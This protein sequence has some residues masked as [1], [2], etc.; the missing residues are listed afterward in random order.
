MLASDARLPVIHVRNGI[1]Y[2]SSAHAKFS[3]VYQKNSQETVIWRTAVLSSLNAVH[4]GDACPVLEAL[5]EHP[6]KR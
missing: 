5:S 4:D 6:C 2:Y 3:F 1:T